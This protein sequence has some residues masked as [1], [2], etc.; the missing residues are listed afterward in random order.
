MESVVACVEGP[1]I[2]RHGGAGQDDVVDQGQMLV[3]HI[4]GRLD[5]VADGDR[6]VADLRRVNG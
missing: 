5:E 2:V 3:A 4:L 1:P 6:I